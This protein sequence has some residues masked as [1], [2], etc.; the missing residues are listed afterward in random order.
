MLWLLCPQGIFLTPILILAT[1]GSEAAVPATEIVVQLTLTVVTPLICGQLIQCSHKRWL[2][3]SHIP[4]SSISSAVL[5]FIIYTAFCDTFSHQDIKVDSISLL[6]MVLTII[7]LQAFLLF[8]VFYVTT[9]TPFLGF[10]PADV[11]ALL[12]L[13]YTQIIDTR[14]FDGISVITIP[15]LIYHPTQILLGGML[16]P[17]LRG[18]LATTAAF[19]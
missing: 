17:T 5:L 8:L 4:F 18:W 19:R 3:R 11:T 14:E 7:A 13:L 15:L 1:V 16:V 9:S 12:F 6:L 2:M 10:R